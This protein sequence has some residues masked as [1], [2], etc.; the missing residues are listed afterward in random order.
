MATKSKI[1]NLRLVY[2]TKSKIDRPISVSQEHK[3]RSVGLVWLEWWFDTLHVGKVQFGLSGSA[4]SEF[5]VG[6]RARP[7]TSKKAK[8]LSAYHHYD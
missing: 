3:V 8:D 4:P 1:T 5:H 6:S 7:A 2:V